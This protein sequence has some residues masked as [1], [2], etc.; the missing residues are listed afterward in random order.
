MRVLLV[1]LPVV[2]GSAFVAYYLTRAGFY[3]RP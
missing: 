3:E 2:V 1:V